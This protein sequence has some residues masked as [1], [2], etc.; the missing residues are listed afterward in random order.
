MPNPKAQVSWRRQGARERGSKPPRRRRPVARGPRLGARGRENREL[1][2]DSVLQM[3][4]KCNTCVMR[5]HWRVEARSSGGVLRMQYIWRTRV[6]RRKT[7][8]SGRVLRRFTRLTEPTASARVPLA[9]HSGEGGCQ[10]RSGCLQDPRSMR[11]CRRRGR[12]AGD[13]CGRRPR[14][15]G[16]NTG[17]EPSRGQEQQ[18]S[19]T[20]CSSSTIYRQPRPSCPW[21]NKFS[22]QYRHQRRPGL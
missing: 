1:G 19:A 14:L 16:S 13:R 18:P 10:S 8:V 17:P 4:Y 5:N 2:L 20:Y 11:I 15:T 6:R 7:R 3:Q 22:A 12:R 9:D 21:R